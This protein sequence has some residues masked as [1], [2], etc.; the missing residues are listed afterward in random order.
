VISADNCSYE[1]KQTGRLAVVTT[2][3]QWN[4]WATLLPT[5]RQWGNKWAWAAIFWTY[6]RPLWIFVIAPSSADL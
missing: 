6:F 1:C 4:T 2:E 3:V 5:R